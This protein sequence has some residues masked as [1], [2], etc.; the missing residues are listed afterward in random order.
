MVCQKRC[1]IVNVSAAN[2]LN[3][4][5]GGVVGG[6]RGFTLLEVLIA[7]A[8]LAIALAAALRATGNVTNSQGA[9]HARLLA[10][11]SAENRLSELR[12][13]RAWPPLG[14]RRFPCAQ[15]AL[16]LQCSETDS[17]TPNPLFR[18]VEVLV[19]SAASGHTVLAT[20]VTML[21]NETARGL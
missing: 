16:A 5:N 2:A 12:L 14:T 13:A 4:S 9:L 19:T 6:Q 7:L 11:F 18:Q 3:V 20:M 21:G 1:G 15:Q 8:I 17:P 10:S